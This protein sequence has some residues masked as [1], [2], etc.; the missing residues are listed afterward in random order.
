VYLDYQS[1]ILLLTLKRGSVNVLAG[2]RQLMRNTVRLSLLV[3]AIAMFAQ[4]SAF[5]QTSAT[6]FTY[7]FPRIEAPGMELAIANINTTTASVQVK[8]FNLDGSI[9]VPLRLSLAAGTQ[10]V[11]GDAHIGGGFVGAAVVESSVPLAVTASMSRGGTLEDVPPSSPAT[12]LLIPFARGGFDAN[13]TVTV[14][15]SNSLT[16]QVAVVLARSN[17]TQATAAN[18][19]LAPG[20]SAD[21]ALN[22]LP[23]A[24]DGF[25]HVLVRSLGNVFSNNRTVSAVAKVTEFD[26]GNGMVR[27]DG[28]VIQGIPFAN[29]SSNAR[30]PIFIRGAGYLTLLQVVNASTSPQ[31]I[32]ITALSAGDAPLPAARNPITISLPANGSF[33]GDVAEIFGFQEQASGSIVISGTGLMAAV[34]L[35]GREDSP[36]LAGIDQIEPAATTFAFQ[37]RSVS[38]DSFYGLSLLN[39]NSASAT[40]SITFIRNDGATI[41]ITDAAVP[42]RSQLIKTVADLL[43]EAEGSGFLFVSSD[44]PIE[45]RAIEGTTDGSAL[46]SLRFSTVTSGFRPNPQNRFL[47]VGTA[48]IDGVPIPGATVRLA[49]PVS[50]TRATDAVG[51]FVF[52]DIPPGSYNLSISMRGVTFTPSSLAFTITD[53]NSRGHNFVGTVVGSALTSIDPVGVLVGTPTAVEIVARGGPFIPTSEIIFEGNVLPTTYVNET[54]LTALLPPAALLVARQCTI[55]VR[56][57]IGQSSSPSGTLTFSIG[58]PAPVIT[59]VLGIPIEIVVGHPGFSVTLIGT[60]FNEGGTV[61]VDGVPRGF[62]YD[63]P[64]QVRAFISPADLAIGRVAKL[65]ATNP[66]PTVGPSNARDITI[67]NPVAGLLAISPNTTT[68]RLEPNSPGLQLT[69]DG[70]S[71]KPGATV[72]VEG[73]PPLN[74]TFVNSTRL[75]A[76]IPPQALEKGGSYR[77]SVSNP[78]PTQ[79]TSEVKGLLVYN[80]IPQLSSVDAGALTFLPG[81][82]EASTVPVPSIVVLYG[83]NF[84]KSTNVLWY[85]PTGPFPSCNGSGEPE[86]LPS[87]RISSTEMVVVAPIKCTGTYQIYVSSNQA[88]PGGG[89]SQILSFTVTDPPVGAVPAISSLF[90][91]SV[92]RGVGFTLRMVGTNFLG[93][94]LVNFG[95][96]IL[97]PSAVTST[98]LVVTIPAYLVQESGIIPVSVTNPGLG[99]TSTRLLFIVN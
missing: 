38:R 90:P 72:T 53:Q 55:Q 21:V 5:G 99:G 3:A 64:T 60:G 81:V 15:N 9:A 52:R 23:F 94:A 85:Q 83:S 31:S 65:T 62:V 32:T 76:Q 27:S 84:G 42:A 69:V 43:P 30:V 82:D 66:A 37:F 89:V 20:Q 54:M 19:T 22:A 78:P 34:A 87:T 75:I 40:V 92:P 96:A 80:L 12:E 61:E 68:T 63:S 36:N 10:A 29:L 11:L 57:R 48:T 33:S 45:A 71:F 17:G 97:V 46:S 7:S 2:D 77:V 91:T 18:L 24:L 70:F 79:G 73:F 35:I 41:S 95:T 67:L 25:T 49:G 98:T 88:E 13:T 74:T 44:Q 6:A 14:F 59:N 51:A 8:F 4:A 86:P 28:A 16:S 58:H 93:G 47:A 26:T 1:R 56:N 50:V 39:T